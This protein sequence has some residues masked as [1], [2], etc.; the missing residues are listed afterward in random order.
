MEKASPELRAFERPRDFILVG[1]DFTV[2]NGLPTPTL[3]LKRREA[4]AVYGAELE[5]LDSKTPVREIA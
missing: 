5:A 4:T 2:A 3:K 1:T